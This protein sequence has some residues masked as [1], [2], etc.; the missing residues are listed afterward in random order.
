MAIISKFGC[1][2]RCDGRTGGMS[3]SW[4]RRADRDLEERGSFCQNALPSQPRNKGS[5]S[6]VHAGFAMDGKPTI[7]L[8]SERMSDNNRPFHQ[9]RR[10]QSPPLFERRGFSRSTFMSSIG[11]AA[12]VVSS[13]DKSARR[14]LRFFPYCRGTCL[15]KGTDQELPPRK[16]ASLV[17]IQ[18]QRAIQFV[19]RHLST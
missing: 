3:G 17:A 4:S 19:S 1:L 13:C 2:N 16:S 10:S 9:S 7:L 11:I 6:K 8:L 18:N 12:T 15:I 5:N 14:L